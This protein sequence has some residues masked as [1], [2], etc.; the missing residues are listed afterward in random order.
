[1]TDFEI[2]ITDDQYGRGITIDDYNGISIV[3]VKQTDKGTYKDWCF[4]QVKDRQPGA[5]AI[6]WKVN[7]G[8]DRQAAIEN[9][10]S[11]MMML[12]ASLGECG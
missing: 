7:I 8:K 4:P 11:L 3:Q 10:R 2:I 5:K 1:M 9:L 6:P 12:G